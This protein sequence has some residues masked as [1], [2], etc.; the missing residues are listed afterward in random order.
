MIDKDVYLASLSL[1]DRKN[2][3]SLSTAFDE[4]FSNQGVAAA[5]LAVGSSVSSQIEKPPS[6]IDVVILRGDTSLFSNFL[7]TAKTLS[8]LTGFPVSESIPPLPD[9]DYPD[10]LLRHA[11]SVRLQ[12]KLGK[13]LE[14]IRKEHA[15]PWQETVDKNEERGLPQC[16][17]VTAGK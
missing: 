10:L 4:L 6:D 3:E 5:L 13:S 12:P 8:Q 1:I 16:I 14:I 7:D 2:L 9:L 17:L 11:G 15:E